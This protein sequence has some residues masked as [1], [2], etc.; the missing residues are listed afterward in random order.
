MEKLTSLLADQQDEHWACEE[1]AWETVLLLKTETVRK[2]G[3]N[4]NY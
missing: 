2:H 4:M 3:N 1:P